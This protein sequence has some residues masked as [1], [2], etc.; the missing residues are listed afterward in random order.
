MMHR[1]LAALCVHCR[2]QDCWGREMELACQTWVFSAKNGKGNVSMLSALLTLSPLS[3]LVIPV[4]S[5]CGVRI[6]GRPACPS[7]ALEH[8]HVLCGFSGVTYLLHRFAR[9]ACGSGALEVQGCCCGRWSG[10]RSRQP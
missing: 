2:M 1:R 8:A 6:A 5:H 7:L 9:D 4:I 10:C 3:Q